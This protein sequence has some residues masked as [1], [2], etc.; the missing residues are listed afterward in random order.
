M[1][2]DET[3]DLANQLQSAF[4]GSDKEIAMSAIIQGDSVGFPLR[5]SDPST[6]NYDEEPGGFD[7]AY[8]FAKKILDADDPEVRKEG[9]YV[10]F[11]DTQSE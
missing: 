6:E 7:E 1:E 4:E 3:I 2:P 8:D 9:G 10:W 11:E 5:I